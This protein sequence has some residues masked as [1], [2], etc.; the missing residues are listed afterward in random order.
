MISAHLPA[1]QVVVPLLAA[2]ICAVLGRP[3]LAW[4]WAVLVSWCTFAIAVAILA[5]VLDTG[6]I[7][8]WIGNWQPPWGIE[9]R[10]DTANA[11]LLVLV[12]FIGAVVMPYARLSVAREIPAERVTWYYT[13]LL[14]CEAGLV[15][16]SATGDA[17]N[18]FVFM[19][20][21]SLSSYV[22][23][24]LGRDRRALV[25]A[26]QYL[27]IGTIGATFYVI[28]IGFLYLAT[29]TLNLADLA[30]RIP[31]VVNQRPILV[32]L[33]FI[34]VGLSLKL[35]LFPLHYWLPAAYS[36][37]PSAAT[38]FLAASATKV[39]AYLLLRFFFSI[40]G[41]SYPFG[42]QAII[43]LWLVLSI[44]AI[45]G[46]SIIAIMQDD[47]KRMLAMSSVAQIGYITLG[48]GLDNETG[49]TASIVHLF[50]HGLMKGALFLLIGG[51]A[52]QTGAVSMDRIA[53]LARRMPWTFA[54]IVIAGLSM[55]GVPGTVGFV[56][57]W[58]LVQAAM[59]RGWWWLVVIIVASSVLA[60][61]YMGRLIEAA[62]LRPAP[63][64]P[65]LQEAPPSM[66]VCAWVLV[67]ACVWFGVDTEMTAQVA[68]R[69]AHGLLGI[70]P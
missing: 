70:T 9:Y 14:L 60:L 61:V 53:G 4:A 43:V 10:I 58:F 6:P 63:A 50:N 31:A 56:S 52:Y 20:I 59:E 25:A 13:M 19:E 18:I 28:G 22:L 29:G 11:F 38:A 40:F 49:L 35:A 33:A 7:S 69:A 54:G 51:I 62:Y 23:I 21:A 3:I 65:P 41:E 37:A 17:F 24:A 55:V 5:Q 32:G 45:V 67:A 27:V 34:T 46:A 15:G 16:M 30:Q 47:V 1:L 64:G 26:Y 12:S 42:D 48:I 57:K 66:L 36:Y 68:S 39:A 44:A 8:Y 2:P